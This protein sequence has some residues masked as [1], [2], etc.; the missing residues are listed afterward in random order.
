MARAGTKAA[1]STARSG[2]LLKR[3]VLRFREPGHLRFDLPGDLAAEPGA[4]TLTESLMRLDGVYRVLVF[5]GAG[6]LSI[7][8]DPA[9]VGETAVIRHLAQ[10]VAALPDA[11][12]T[13]RS[14]PF[15]ASGLR[16]MKGRLRSLPLVRWGEE[17]LH[18]AKLAA[19]AVR[20][21][22]ELKAGRG[23]ALPFD[24]KEWGIHFINDLVAFYLIR[25]HWARITRQ[26]LPSPWTYRYQWLTI[27][28]LTFILVRYRKTALQKK[29][30]K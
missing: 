15:S 5:S 29:A 11:K 30:A 4:G 17:K 13:A 10:A 7:R 20:N 1:R 9:A 14:Q 21:L 3:F 25:V 26:W 28:Y 16:D 6:K 12:E 24:P 8:Y 27:I 22:A 19:G 23:Q 18:Q 2:E